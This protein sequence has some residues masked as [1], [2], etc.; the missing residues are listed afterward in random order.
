MRTLHSVG[1]MLIALALLCVAAA[2]VTVAEPAHTA[3]TAAPSLWI[4]QAESVAAARRSLARVHARAERELDIIHAVSAHLNPWQLEQLRA[5]ADVRLFEDRAL[6]TRGSLLQAVTTQVVSTVNSVSSATNA[7]VATSPV[8]VITSG[9]ATPLAAS[10]LGTPVVSALTSPVVAG[11]SA[12]THTQDGSGVAAA[13]LLYQTNY[14]M[15]VGADTLQQAGI[16]GKGVTIA[17]LDTGL[18][19]DVSQNYGARVLATLDVV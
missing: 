17:V 7:A 19:Q 6:M 14:P 9:A 16:S 8:G 2:P 15:L 18:W 11:M 13:T 4:V 3:A 1:S 10:L 12:G 5:S